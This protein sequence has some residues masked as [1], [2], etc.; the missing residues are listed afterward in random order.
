L[1]D[2]SAGGLPIKSKESPKIGD[3]V[4]VYI[5]NL[6]RFAGDVIRTFDGGFAIEINST[7]RKKDR[8]AEQ[9]SLYAEGAEPDG[10]QVRRH[11]GETVGKNSELRRTD[12][13]TIRCRIVDMSM[14]GLAIA[15]ADRPPIGEI[16][17]IGNMEGRVVRH[18]SDGI[19]IEFSKIAPQ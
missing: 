17:E 15:I 3:N 6:G 7:Q 12:G 19:G 2:I 11:V 1:L 16:I 18:S 9:L 4:I 5:D 10:P 13:T 14:S 8:L